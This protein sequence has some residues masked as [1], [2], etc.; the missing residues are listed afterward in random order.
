MAQEN[1]PMCEH[2][3]HTEACTVIIPFKMI[4]GR[5]VKDAPCNCSGVTV[6]EDED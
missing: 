5:F 2:P 4:G 6:D 1:C 3:T